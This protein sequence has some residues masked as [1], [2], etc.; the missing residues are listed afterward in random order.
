MNRYQILGVSTFR[1]TP[2]R[3]RYYSILKTISKVHMNANFSCVKFFLS[4]MYVFLQNGLM[5]SQDTSNIATTFCE[6]IR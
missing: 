5:G 4:I 6:G 2:S 3:I 1:K